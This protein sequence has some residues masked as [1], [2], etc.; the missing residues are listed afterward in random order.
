MPPQ[1]TRLRHFLPLLGGWA[2]GMSVWLWF[3]F[4]VLIGAISG[5]ALERSPT[6]P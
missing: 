5:N 6:A 2:V 3:L 4:D 1:L